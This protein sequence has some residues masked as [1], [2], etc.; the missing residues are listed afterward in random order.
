VQAHGTGQQQEAV[1]NV[2]KGGVYTSA[3]PRGWLGV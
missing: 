1:L 3:H 2:R